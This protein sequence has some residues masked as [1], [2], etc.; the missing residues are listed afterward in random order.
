MVFIFAL[1]SWRRNLFPAI[2]ARRPP[3]PAKLA[4][5]LP[6]MVCYA[7][8]CFFSWRPW[9]RVVRFSPG[10]FGL[11]ATVCRQRASETDFSDLKEP[12]IMLTIKRY[13]ENSR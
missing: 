2:E 12:A 5:F 6:L 3:H 8:D 13:D 7:P 1:F 9:R 10:L 4:N 11:T